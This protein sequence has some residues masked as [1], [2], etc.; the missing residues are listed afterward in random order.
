[1]LHVTFCLGQL[2]SICMIPLAI[3]DDSNLGPLGVRTF[4]GL[5]QAR[6]PGLRQKSAPK[7]IRGSPGLPGE[8]ITS[9][10]LFVLPRLFRPTRSRNPKGGRAAHQRPLRV[11]SR[12]VWP[13]L[14]RAV[15][16]YAQSGDG[17]RHGLAAIAF[18]A[19]NS[20]LRPGRVLAL[21]GT[22]LQTFVIN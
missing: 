12:P 20:C 17:F 21:R 3:G 16:R 2:P 4:P 7:R 18:D 5:P 1:M 10:S 19:W 13:C 8:A 14:R 15:P 6:Q 11:C 9:G 22:D